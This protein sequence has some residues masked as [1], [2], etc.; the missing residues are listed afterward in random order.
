[1]EMSLVALAIAGVAAA[2]LHGVARLLVWGLLQ[3]LRWKS[4][5]RLTAVVVAW[6]TASAFLIWPLYAGLYAA[7]YVPSLLLEDHEWPFLVWLAGCYLVSVVPFGIHVS[8]SRG[9]IF[10]AGREALIA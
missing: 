7:V 5:F 1:M 6:F 4:A 9:R 8:R 3:I 2:V 10:R